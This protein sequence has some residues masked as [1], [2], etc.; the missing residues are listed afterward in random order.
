MSPRPRVPLP[1]S[2]LEPNRRR[3]TPC[4][5]SLRPTPTSVLPSLPGGYMILA[6]ALFRSP[7]VMSWS[8]GQHAAQLCS[9]CNAAR[10]HHSSPGFRRGS[11]GLI[12]SRRLIHLLGA[13]SPRCGLGSW[14]TVHLSE[15][16]IGCGWK[17]LARW[18]CK[19][20]QCRCGHRIGS[21]I[22]SGWWGRAGLS[23]LWSGDSFALPVRRGA[24]VP[25]SIDFR[26]SLTSSSSTKKGVG[27]G[28][29]GR[30]GRGGC[31]RGCTPVSF[32]LYSVGVAG[33]SDRCR[34]ARP[35]E[36]VCVLRGRMH[37]YLSFSFLHV[38]FVSYSWSR[39]SAGRF[40][41][42]LRVQKGYNW[43]PWL[44]SSVRIL[45]FRV[46]LSVGGVPARSSSF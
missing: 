29:G 42:P 35:K 11:H 12:S 40:M 27:I 34:G 5:L 43:P 30:C 8:T 24:A 28:V 31:G 19:G 37:S 9:A 17:E 10:Y 2:S 20:R 33:P 38:W 23:W 21:S 14:S 4:L 13:I 3:C 22:V 18:C 26:L 39:V 45:C 25:L 6:T 36:V 46:R 16:G 7:A 41:L 15:R 32:P 1:S 44:F